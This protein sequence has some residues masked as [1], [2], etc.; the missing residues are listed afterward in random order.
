MPG[1]EAQRLNFFLQ[2]DTI[3]AQR[4][5]FL[6][7]AECCGA[8]RLD[9]FCCDGILLFPVVHRFHVKADIA[10]G[11]REA[12]LD[13]QHPGL[14]SVET[15]FFPCQVEVDARLV[16]LQPCKVLLKRYAAAHQ[17][18]VLPLHQVNFE[19]T[20]G[21]PELVILFSSSCLSLQ[22]TNRLL[23]LRHDVVHPDE[24]LLHAFQ[25][26]VRRFPS[27][28]ILGDAGRLLEQATPFI[29][30]VAENGLHHL[31]LDHRI[32]VG[33]HTGVHEQV[34]NI[35]QPARHLIQEVLAFTGSVH[36]AAHGDLAVFGRQNPLGVLDDER[37]LG[38]AQGFP[39]LCAVE[40]DVFHFV[41]A[42]RAIPLLAQHPAN[43][44][45]DIRLAAA[46]RAHDRGDPAVESK[47]HLVRERLEADNFQF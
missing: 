7:Q 23:H 4:F 41:A 42:Q 32:R 25:L 2:A 46:V 11:L 39:C 34:Q 6:F 43:G 12:F 47:A 16:G 20:E 5:P 9:P 28:L 45:D 18:R 17:L 38:H 14:Q 27:V 22:R 15:S 19:R 36:A 24:I 37:R 30:L 13:I 10:L 21:G 44:I 40:D 8:Q 29:G 3:P 35:L 33:P 26:A 1:P 31:Q